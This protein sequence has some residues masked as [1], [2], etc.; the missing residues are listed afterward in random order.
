MRIPAK[1]PVGPVIA[2]EYL[3]LSQRDD[4]EDGAKVY[5]TAIVVARGSQTN[6]VGLCAWDFAQITRGGRASSGGRPKLKR[7]LGLDDEPSW[8]QTDQVK[9]SAAGPNH[10]PHRTSSSLPRVPG[11]LRGRSTAVRPVR[12]CASTPGP[13]FPAPYGEGCARTA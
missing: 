10:P 9:V 8:I 1:P 5:P 3:W 12:H 11:N 4:R 6:P 7:H 2:H 13:R